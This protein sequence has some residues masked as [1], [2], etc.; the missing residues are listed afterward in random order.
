MRGTNESRPGPSRTLVVDCSSTPVS[1]HICEE[2]LHEYRW[3]ASL[4]FPYVA[5]RCGQAIC[6]LSLG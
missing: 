1:F 4:Y 3:F 5:L 6:K 2:A